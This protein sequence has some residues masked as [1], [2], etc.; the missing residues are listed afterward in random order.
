MTPSA[1]VFDFDGTIADTEWGVYVVVRDAF[2]AHG[3]D[4]TLESWVEIIGTAESGTLEEL[5]EDALGRPPDREKIEAARVAQ[6][7]V[8]ASSP[9]LPG[10]AEVIGAAVAAGLPLAVASSSPSGW[11]EFQEVE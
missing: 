10:V 5:L 4:V 1:I 2:R 3:L 7:E 11:V 6:S 8:R 9:M